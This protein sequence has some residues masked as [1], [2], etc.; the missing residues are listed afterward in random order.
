MS[1]H[2]SPPNIEQE[3]FSEHGA[4][5]RLGGVALLVLT[6]IALA[7]SLYQLGIAAFQIGR[8]SCRERV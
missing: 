5:R 2:V 1:A 7:F 3:T 8:A 4:Q 6:G